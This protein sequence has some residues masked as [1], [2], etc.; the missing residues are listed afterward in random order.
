MEEIIE[1]VC[2]VMLA[3]DMDGRRCNMNAQFVRISV[4]IM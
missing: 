3:D 4:C 2:V 1:L